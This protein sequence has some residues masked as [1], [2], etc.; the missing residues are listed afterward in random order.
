MSRLRSPARSHST[1]SVL[2]ALGFALYILIVGI[3]IGWTRAS[4]FVVAVVAGF[5]IFL[6]VRYYGEDEPQR[7]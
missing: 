3:A 7:P 4:A 2:W 5:G 6:L 1:T